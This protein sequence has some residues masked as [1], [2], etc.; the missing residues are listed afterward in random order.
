MG[1]DCAV[2]AVDLASQVGSSWELGVKEDLQRL[3]IHAW[4]S[5]ANRDGQ[6]QGQV[7]ESVTGTA[8]GT[9]KSQAESRVCGSHQGIEAAP[10]SAR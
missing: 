7:S 5:T 2:L 9:E 4:E 6:G 10:V 8:H 1:H 3:V